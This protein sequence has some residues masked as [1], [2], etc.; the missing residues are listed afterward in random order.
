MKIVIGG[1]GKIGE[2][3]CR[4][5]VAEGHEIQMIDTDPQVIDKLMTRYDVSGI[6]G[7]ITS[8]ETQVEAEVGQADIFVAAAPEDEV[9]LTGAIIAKRIGSRYTIARVRDPE[10]GHHMSFV[11]DSL[12][13]SRLINPELETARKLEQILRFPAAFGVEQFINGHVMMLECR[14]GKESDLAGLDLI[15]FRSLFPGI[16]VTALSHDEQVKIPSGSDLLM[17]GDRLLVTGE[18]NDLGK[19]YHH[20]GSFTGKLKNVLLIGGG[21]IAYYL[22]QLMQKSSLSFTVIERDEDVANELAGTF[23]DVRV[24]VEDGTDFVTLSELNFEEF[25]CVV[26]LTGVDEENLIIGLFAA[27]QHIPRIITKVSRTELIH[28]VDPDSVQTIITPKRIAA[29]GVI[30]KVRG[31]QYSEGSNVEVLYRLMSDTIEALEFK[32]KSESELIGIPIRDLKLKPNL[33]IAI[34]YRRGHAIFPT[35]QDQIEAGDHV[36]V[37]AQDHRLEDLDDIL[38]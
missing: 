24:I 18:R 2:V 31:L 22:L 25:D 23:P 28:Y 37:V 10:Y 5:L 12:G 26:A 30:R 9:N 14:I 17:H 13:I 34:I 15:R 20:L 19:L 29:D 27:H 36:I 8:I 3:L 33:L 35:G 11:Q 6:V 16:L 32:V 7:S 38:A 1:G 4:D 21:R